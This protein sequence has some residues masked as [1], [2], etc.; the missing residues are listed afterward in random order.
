[1]GHGVG[2]TVVGGFA[3]LLGFKAKNKDLRRSLKDLRQISAVVVQSQL[4]VEVCRLMFDFYP[5]GVVPLA[6]G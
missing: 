1:M 3:H 6:Q 4:L 2:G 5:N